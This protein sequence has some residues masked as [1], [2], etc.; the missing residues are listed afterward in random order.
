M[1][2]TRQLQE[3]EPTIKVSLRERIAPGFA[4]N[5]SFR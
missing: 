4:F 3:R 1:G 5:F 2:G